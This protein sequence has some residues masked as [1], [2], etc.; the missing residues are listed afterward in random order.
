[1]GDIRYA[2]RNL[3]RNPGFAATAILSLALGIGAN[4]A[5]FTLI[6][7]VMWRMLPV[8]AP[9]GLI[10][11]DQRQGAV[12]Q[13]GFSYQQYALIR[14]NSRVLTLAAYA[15]V[16]LNV[17]IDGQVEPTA[18]GQMVSGSYFPLLGV[19]A[20]AGRAF[21][22]DDDR[23]PSGHPVA[24]I[25]Y[26]YWQRRFG[27][28]PGIIGRPITLSGAPFTIVG[29]TPPEFFG[30]E[31]GA[32]PDVFV[33]IMMQPVVM[34]VAENLLVN[35]A[36]FLTWVHAIARLEPGV[37][38]AQ[39]S[40]TLATLSELPEFSGRDKRGQIINTTLTMD[41]AAT[42]LSDL[43]DQFST[44][45]RILMVVVAIILLI[46]CANTGGLLLA[47]SA[48]RRAEFAVRVALGA[49]R[50]RLMR[51]VLIEGLLLASLAGAC[52]IVLAY[53]V[54]RLLVAHV[55]AGRSPITLDLSPDL[56]VLLFATMVSIL[57][58]VLFASVP[59]VRASRLAA[60]AGGPRD[61]TSTRHAVANLRPA[62]ALV[63]CQVTLSLL[64]LVTAGLF[65]RSLQ[66]LN[67]RDAG[68]DRSQ[69]LIVRVEPKGS[70]QRNM[71]G[72]T[73]RLDR[74]YRDLLARVEQLPGVRAA[75]LARTT[76]LT[77]MSF[78]G[79]VT[80]PAGDLR[81]VPIMMVYPHYFATMGLALAQGRDFDERDLR[82]DAPL[83][84]LVNETFVRD[85]LNGQPP[86]GPAA[87]VTMDGRTLE[88]IGVVKDSPYPDLRS[89]PRPMLYQTFRQ[90]RTGRG[91][92]VLHA[93][94]AG[95]IG[96]VLPELRD[97]VQSIDK[98]TPM[99]DV[100]SLKDE[101][102]AT[103]VRE[104][105]VTTLSSAFGLVALVLVSVGLF[106]VMS[107]TVSRRTAEIG[108]RVALGAARFDV[109]WMIARQTLALVLIGIAVA[110]PIAWAL[111]R[112]ASHQ[113]SV[114]LFGVTPFDPVTL[115]GA[116]V[117]LIVVA[118]AAG[119]LP[120]WRAVRI[121]PLVAL[122]ND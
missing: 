97:A 43:R 96:T 76:P 59:A 117:L 31:V 47:R 84:T 11:L 75:S 103:L 89:A 8:H 61:L 20:A 37:A 44:P 42:G 60:T 40:A 22:P 90:T 33:P 74:I 94:I 78:G 10:V 92:M 121:D 87:K 98:D 116:T 118:A 64:L 115:A 71:P 49:S 82:P 27:L 17:R 66:K 85:V 26:G 68:M 113:L 105:L 72:V 4:T 2:L 81:E 106:G 53:Y 58:G 83:V 109:A 73:D 110:V 13:H 51:Q 104:R 119:S 48:A 80:S 91:Q 23:I 65:V 62:A 34:P 99:F 57:T 50:A 55:S 101:L 56:R 15:R 14:D 32:S 16:R 35:P 30:V 107:F 70:D 88:I 9:E 122:R 18:E 79:R 29:V 41:R 86:R 36:Q 38:P 111:G 24:M 108:L 6:N 21:G 52:G 100:H 39:A 67:Q 112:I 54:T 28:D 63:V 77:P 95:T 19:S 5:L 102:D 3:R 1:M 45:L 114:M 120:T 69:I 7:T 12:V 25:S 46:A 93:R